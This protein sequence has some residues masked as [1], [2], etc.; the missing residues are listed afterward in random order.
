MALLIML[1]NIMWQIHQHFVSLAY[2]RSIHARDVARGA[3]DYFLLNQFW[4]TANSVTV[5]LWLAGPRLSVLEARRDRQKAL[6]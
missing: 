5:P 6:V 2:L 3:T 4:K 1:P